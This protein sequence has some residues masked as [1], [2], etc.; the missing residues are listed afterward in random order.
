LAGLAILWKS[1]DRLKQ[2]PVVRIFRRAPLEGAGIEVVPTY[3]SPQVTMA[4]P[5]LDVL[6]GKETQVTARH[7]A[8]RRGVHKLAPCCVLQAVLGQQ[9]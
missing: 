5:R 6:L 9:V 4:H 1:S 7:L 2:F 3:R 8:L